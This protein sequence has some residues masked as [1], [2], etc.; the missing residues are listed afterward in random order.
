VGVGSLAAA[1]GIGA[2]WWLCNV[3]FDLLLFSWGPMK[4]PVAA[5]LTDIGLAYNLYPLV[6]TGL[7]V[8]SRPRM[9]TVEPAS[10]RQALA[11]PD[12]TTQCA[13]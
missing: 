10:S 3:G 6:L 5:Y 9:S 8:V 7:Y 11:L 13:E 4:M 1:V 12:M 2:F